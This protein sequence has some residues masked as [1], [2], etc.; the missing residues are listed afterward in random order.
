MKNKLRKK[1]KEIRKTLDI[2]TI[3]E[4]L[5]QLIRRNKDYQNAQNI[6]LYYPT[7][8]EMN[9]LSLLQDNKNFYFPRVEGSELLVCPFQNGDKLECS[10]LGI[11][12][13][14]TKPESKKILDLVI[15][16]ALMIDKNGH[17]LGYGGGF[18]DRFLQD[19]NAKTICAIPK[20]L[21]VENLPTEDFDVPVNIVITV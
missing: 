13:P 20:E 2:I 3:S 9:F 18:Y 4:K 7:K 8:Y 17:R 16:P 15:V 5:A 11:L 1:A 21:Y 12:E 6:L 19:L 14:C 10:S